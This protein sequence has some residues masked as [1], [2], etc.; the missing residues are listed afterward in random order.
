MSVKIGYRLDAIAYLHAA[1][2][3]AIDFHLWGAVL[4]VGQNTPLLSEPPSN[5]FS[6]TP[7]FGT[8]QA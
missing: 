7:V 8:S 4:I 3:A 1:D 5:N 6:S 2:D